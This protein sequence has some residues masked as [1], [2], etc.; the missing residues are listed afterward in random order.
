MVL[1]IEAGDLNT[2][3]IPQTSEIF[4]R[5]IVYI[6][7]KFSVECSFV[8]LN[9]KVISFPSLEFNICSLKQRMK[10]FVQRNIAFMILRHFS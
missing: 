6:I 8:L 9:K 7:F 5:P 4:P 10:Y 3:Q 2:K 1:S